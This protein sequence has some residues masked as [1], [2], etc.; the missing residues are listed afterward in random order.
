MSVEENIE[1]Y[2]VG[3]SSSAYIT[4]KQNKS[5]HLQKSE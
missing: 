1:A 5:E 4:T 3:E 2:M